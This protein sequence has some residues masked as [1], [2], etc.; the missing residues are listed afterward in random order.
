MLK[1]HSQSFLS[2]FT[3]TSPELETLG[4]KIFVMKKLLG[5][6]A[7]NPEPTTS[8]TLNQPFSYGLPEKLLLGGG[9]FG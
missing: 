3:H 6:E 1:L 8:F 2:A 5:G 9:R 7:G 4:W